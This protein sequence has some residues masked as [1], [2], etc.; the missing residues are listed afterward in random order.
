MKPQLQEFP[1]LRDVLAVSCLPAVYQ[2]MTQEMDKA[3]ELA[4]QQADEMLK[5][6]AKNG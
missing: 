2:S 5:A 4:Y 6:R 3:A 1:S